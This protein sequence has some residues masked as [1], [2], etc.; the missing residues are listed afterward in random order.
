MT[1]VVRGCT[2]R[3][4]SDSGRVVTALRSA[5]SWP[6]E[7]REPVKAGQA[8]LLATAMVVTVTAPLLV[9]DR[10]ARLVLLLVTG[11]MS[12]VL[13][14]SL[15]LPW[16]RLPRRCTLMFPVLVWVALAALGLGGHGLATPYGGLFVLCFAYTGLTQPAATSLWL[17]GPAATSY[18]AAMG[19]WSTALG[20][21]LMIVM[22]VWVLLSQLL[23]GLTSRQQVLTDALR[24]AA[25]TDALTGLPNR[26]DLDLRLT[27]AAAGDTVVLCDLDHFKELNDTL[28]HAAGDRV[29]AEF[30]LLLHACLRPMDYSARYGG[31]EFALLLP[32][33]TIGQARNVLARLRQRWAILHPTVT[34]SA[35]LA[36][37]TSDTGGGAALEAADRALY[38][39]KAGGRNRDHC[40]DDVDSR[41]SVRG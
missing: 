28:G 16:Q 30:G 21:R 25:H 8:L 32:E 26:R 15:V 12:A 6:V 22:A 14:I 17:V 27:A 23:A 4:P 39:A 11:G 18:V 38:A 3:R 24:S 1:E 10:H 33:T 36:A 35:G 13:L 19:S 41:D 37:C 34:F 2:G 7:R 20:I 40:A 31:E 5:L 9:F 29:L